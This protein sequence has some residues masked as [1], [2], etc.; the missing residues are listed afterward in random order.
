MSWTRPNPS[1]DDGFG[2]LVDDVSPDRPPLRLAEPAVPGWPVW[3]ETWV[4]PYVREPSLW[5]VLVALLGHVVVG[6]APLVLYVV[7]TGSVEAGLVLVGLV[8]AS[9]GLVGFEVFRFRWP[10]GVTAALVA[11]WATSL[12]LAWVAD[13]TGTF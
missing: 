7:R 9:V 5:P 6:I 2:R 10:G 12:G 13:R 4:L 3:I 8:L 11:T 1:S